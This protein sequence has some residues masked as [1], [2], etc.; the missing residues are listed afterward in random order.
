[1]LAKVESKQIDFALK[2]YPIKL[3][4]IILTVLF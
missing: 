1:M 2:V 4:R 3:Q